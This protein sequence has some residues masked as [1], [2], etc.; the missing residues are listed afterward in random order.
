MAIYR[1]DTRFTGV[2]EQD[3][4]FLVECDGRSC[5]RTLEL[6]FDPRP[7]TDEELAKRAITPNNWGARFARGEVPAKH[8]CPEHRIRPTLNESDV[9]PEFLAEYITPAPGESVPTARVWEEYQN[10]IENQPQTPGFVPGKHKVFEGVRSAGGRNSTRSIRIDGRQTTMP[11]FRDVELK[12]TTPGDHLE[13]YE[14]HKGSKIGAIARKKALADLATRTARRRDEQK[15]AAKL[16][17]HDLAPKVAIACAVKQCAAT[18]LESAAGDLGWVR[19]AIGEYELYACLEHAERFD[20]LREE[21]A[22]A[23]DRDR[24][25]IPESDLILDEDLPG[26]QPPPR[27]KQ[28]PEELEA[29]IAAFEAEPDDAGHIPEDDLEYID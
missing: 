23:G 14:R 27:R 10:F 7:L 16:R 18:A 21:T 5:K 19:T 26:A 6:D 25:V 17:Y 15:A 24:L 22:P 1:K 20:R 8:Y 13:W 28:T 4:A 2:E 12:V 11:V 3:Q 29:A 9:V